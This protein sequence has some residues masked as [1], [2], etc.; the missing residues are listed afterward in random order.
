VKLQSGRESTLTYA[1]KTAIRMFLKPVH[2]VQGGGRVIPIPEHSPTSAPSP[3]S[4]AE[5]SRMAFDEEKASRGAVSKYENTEYCGA[6]NNICERLFSM[7]GELIYSALRN[8]EAHGSGYTEYASLSQG[9]QVL[10]GGQVH[11]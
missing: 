3:L 2:A 5:R 4:I 9:Q 10:M 8:T 11:Y 6:E 7:I 1:E